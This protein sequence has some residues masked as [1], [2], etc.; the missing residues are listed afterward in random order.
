MN[1]ISR[2]Y[3]N[4][5]IRNIEINKDMLLPFSK[6]TS[7]HRQTSLEDNFKSLNSFDGNVLDDFIC[8]N[9]GFYGMKFN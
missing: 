5:S 9:N 7:P 2:T 1:N 3:N 4:S 6:N 8:D